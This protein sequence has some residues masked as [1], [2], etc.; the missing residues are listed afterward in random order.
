MRNKLS[1]ICPK[2][3]EISVYAENTRDGW[4]IR[5]A[6]CNLQSH[7]Y[8]TYRYA[9]QDWDRLVES[10]KEETEVSKDQWTPVSQ[11]P[12]EDGQYLA[13]MRVLDHNFIMIIG[14]A[15]NLREVDEYDF[16]EEKAGWFDYDSETGYY[17]VTD[18]KAWMPLPPSYQGE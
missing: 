9:R 10:I 6:H 1:E 14:Y 16:Q 7:V 4:F 2:C 18:V 17:E 12:K 8:L 13:S 5:C 15:T 11:P 3:R